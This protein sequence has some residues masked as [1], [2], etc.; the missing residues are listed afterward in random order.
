MTA[1]PLRIGVSTRALF[2]LEE[3][4][5]VFKNEGVKAYAKIQVERENVALGK[6]GSFRCC[7]ENLIVK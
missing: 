6:G 3:E 1:T 7:R 2:N 4:H 5:L